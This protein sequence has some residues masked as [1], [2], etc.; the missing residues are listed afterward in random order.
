[1]A[2]R[3]IDA[4]D[5]VKLRVVFLTHM[6]SDHTVGYPDLILTPWVLGRKVP[7]E[8]YGPA[9]IK[10]MTKHMLE[11]YRVDFE[12]RQ[13]STRRACTRWAR[14][15]QGTRSSARDQ[16]RRRLPGCE[17][18]GHGIRHQ[19]HDGELRVSLRNSR[20]S[21]V[22]SGDTNPTQATIDAC[23]GCDVLVQRC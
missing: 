17:R 7:L 11:A 23:N 10:D 8:V 13:S 21:I 19:T 5:P 9:G 12:S 2:E 22:F 16:A 3:G 14:S 4:L 6:H 1:M 18:H 20:R 15:R